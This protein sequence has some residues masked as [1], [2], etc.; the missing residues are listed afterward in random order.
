MLMGGA[1]QKTM[2][3]EVEA[4]ERLK[5]LLESMPHE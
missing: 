4:T 1:V 2:D 5:S 3:T